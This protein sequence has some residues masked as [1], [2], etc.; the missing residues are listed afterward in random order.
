MKIFKITVIF[1]VLILSASVLSAKDQIMPLAVGNIWTYSF[2]AGEKMSGT[3]ICEITGTEE[4]SGIE[5]FKMEFDGTIYPAGYYQLYTIDDGEAFFW[6][7]PD[8]SIRP[9]HS[10]VIRVFPLCNSLI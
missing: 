10:M 1:T 4:V 6:G 2:S 5:A 3:Y 8:N 7:D 9:S